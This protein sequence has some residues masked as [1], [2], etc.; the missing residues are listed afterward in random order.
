VAAF[1]LGGLRTVEFVDGLCSPPRRRRVQR[2]DQ[3]AEERASI[4]VGMRMVAAGAARRIV[5][6]NLRYAERLLAES[7]VAGSAAGLAVRLDRGTDGAAAIVVT[8]SDSTLA[9]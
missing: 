4:E 8:R 2:H 5:L 3:L 6:C 9:N 1:T 7:V